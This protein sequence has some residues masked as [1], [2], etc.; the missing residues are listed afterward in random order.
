M[1][2]TRSASVT[3]SKR[4]CVISSAVF[5]DAVSVAGKIALKNNASLSVDC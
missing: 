3:A 4:S 2:K 1:T 5:R